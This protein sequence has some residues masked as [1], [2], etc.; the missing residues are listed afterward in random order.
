MIA[1]MAGRVALGMIEAKPV[2]DVTG[3]VMGTLA[4]ILFIRNTAIKEDADF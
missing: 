1:V 2:I 4:G 3:K